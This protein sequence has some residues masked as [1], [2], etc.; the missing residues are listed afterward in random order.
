MSDIYSAP[1]AALMPSGAVDGHGSIRRALSGDYRFAVGRILREAWSR[2][3]GSKWT[4]QLAFAIYVG[5]LIVVFGTFGVLGLMLGIGDDTASLPVSLAMQLM[6]Q[7]AYM[8]VATPMY[9]GIFILGLRRAMGAS[10]HAG[11]ILNHYGKTL[12]LFITALLKTIIVVLLTAAT[13]FVLYAGYHYAVPVTLLILFYFVVSLVFAE[14]L[15]VDKDFS[16]LKAMLLSHR[17]VG[18]KLLPMAG[19]LVLLFIINVL[20]LIPLTLGLI[21]SIPLSVIALGIAYRD[22]FGCEKATVSEQ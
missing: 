21:W 18:R 22:M 17:A 6:S 7:L 8:I 4:F 5:V 13:S 20:A 9:T 14:M 15:I 10:I 2:T 19:L 3:G 11:Q 12:P 1:N 16:A